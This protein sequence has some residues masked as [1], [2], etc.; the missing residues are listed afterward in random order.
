M[1]T[2]PSMA[3]ADTLEPVSLKLERQRYFQNISSHTGKHKVR[4]GRRRGRE[5]ESSVHRPRGQRG[6]PGRHCPGL[7]PR[8][9][10]DVVPFHSETMGPRRA[11]PPRVPNPGFV[12]GIA[13]PVRDTQQ[14]RLPWNSPCFPVCG[15][16]SAPHL[17]AE[18]VRV[19]G[20]EGEADRLLQ[21]FGLICLVQKKF[22]GTSHTCELWKSNHLQRECIIS[23]SLT[24]FVWNLLVWGKIHD[25]F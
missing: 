18:L 1:K 12:C 6:G 24:N 2:R 3:T 13:W 23:Q 11:Q 16:G 17:W 14:A 5:A 25:P 4:R 22:L 19:K 21:T 7:R 9:L 15:P 8:V 10:G 20:S